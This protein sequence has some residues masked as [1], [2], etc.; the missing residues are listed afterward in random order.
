ML[1]KL[2]AFIGRNKYEILVVSFVLLIF[3]D[4]PRSM[5]FSII[6][7]P[8]QNMVVALFVFFDEKKLRYTIGSMI[9]LTIAISLFNCCYFTRLGAG[10]ILVIYFLYFILISLKVYQKIFT[11]RR[12]SAEMMAT[13]LCG[14]IL[15]CLAGAILFITIEVNMPHSYSN[16]GLGTVRFSN[17]SYF[18]FTTLLTIGYGDIVPLTLTAK[19]SVMLMGLTGHIYTVFLTGIIIGKY[20]QAEQR[21]NIA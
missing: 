8:L 20:I 12:V 9:G 19:R 11:A 7:L 2:R 3:G 6:L 1:N 21:H 18:S 16:V 17:L 13:V 5:V 10:I 14:F 4:M 15:L